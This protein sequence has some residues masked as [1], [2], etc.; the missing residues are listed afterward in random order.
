MDVGVKRK[1]E[2]EAW[3]KKD[4]LLIVK[5]ALLSNGLPETVIGSLNQTA[6]AEV[7]AAITFAKTGP[8]PPKEQLLDNVFRL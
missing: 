6:E 3:R 2:L 1:S 7:A 8:L 5:R 4:P